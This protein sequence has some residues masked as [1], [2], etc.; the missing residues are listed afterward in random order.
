MK[1]KKFAIQQT[2]HV[3]TPVIKVPQD[4]FNLFVVLDFLAV[5]KKAL[6]RPFT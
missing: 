4:I 5:C 6:Y 3:D 2:Q 1:I